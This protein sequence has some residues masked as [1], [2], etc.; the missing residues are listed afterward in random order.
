[1]C[2]SV[3]TS[4]PDT[5]SDVCFRDTLSQDTPSD[6]CFRGTLISRYALRCVFPW[7][8]HL[9]IRPLMCVFVTPSLKIRPPMCV[10]VAPSSPDTPSDVCVPGTQ[11]QRYTL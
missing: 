7:Q 11:I 8:P 5:P 9:Q 6:V 3:A 4:S 1:M 2:V 10:S